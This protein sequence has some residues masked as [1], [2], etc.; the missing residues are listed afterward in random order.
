MSNFGYVGL[1]DENGVAYGVK[2]V[3]NKPRVSSMP[4]TYDV[5][6]GNVSDHEPWSMMGYNPAMVA[7]TE[8]DI[9]SATGTYNWMT[10]ATQL[11]AVSSTVNDW[12]S[13]IKTGATNTGSLTTVVDTTANFTGATA[14]AI[15]DVVLLDT[16][17]AEFGYVST[18]SATTL[19]VSGGFSN[20]GTASGRSYRIVDASVGG[21]GARVIRLTGLD[22]NWNEQSEF[23]VM[24]GTTASVSNQSDWY[25]INSFRVVYTGS[26]Y[27]SDGNLIIR[28]VPGTDTR[29]F[30]YITAGY[31]RARN[32]AYTVPAGKT[33]YVTNL[34]TSYGYKSNSTH[35]A[36]FYTRATQDPSGFRTPG[37]FQAYTEVMNS[38]DTTV[39]DFTVPTK[40]NEKVDIKVSGIA[41][42]AGAASVVLRGWLEDM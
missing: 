26:L 33:L 35:Y 42:F 1:K 15:G 36:R 9:W 38:N 5:A 37:L 27:K 8:A 31:T 40:L 24:S 6:E 34:F 10:G 32:I 22:T 29:T 19:Y 20:G 17:S 3:N 18:V 41:T 13:I 14:V 23:I 21:T 30:R 2:H 4:Y 25:R 7:D 28:G 16:T 12:G 39:I 11:E